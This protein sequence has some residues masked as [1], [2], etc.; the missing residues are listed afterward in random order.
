MEA[1]RIGDRAMIQLL[2]EFGAD[3]NITNAVSQY[4]TMLHH[5]RYKYT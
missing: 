2:I 3:P 4:H 1:S 5:Q